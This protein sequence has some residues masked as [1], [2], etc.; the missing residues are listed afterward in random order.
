MLTVLYDRRSKVTFCRWSRAKVCF[1]RIDD[2]PRRI[3]DVRFWAMAK[4]ASMTTL[5]AQSRLAVL[6]S[7]SN[8]KPFGG[9]PKFAQCCCRPIVAHTVRC[10]THGCRAINAS[11]QDYGSSG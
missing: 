9:G 2:L 8:R 5:R 6:G 1:W 10:R 3:Q 11:V 4:P 7:E